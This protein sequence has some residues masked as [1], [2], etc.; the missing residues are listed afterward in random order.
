M[1]HTHECNGQGLP[2]YPRNV[3]MKDI[4]V[5]VHDSNMVMTHDYSCT[6]CRED[7]AVLD[8]STGIMQPCWPCREKGYKVVKY[9]KRS[10]RE[11]FKSFL[12][13]F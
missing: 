1:Q 5:W 13:G 10:W 7:H 12:K 8:G 6:V 2:N 9:D 3:K 4:N 11:R